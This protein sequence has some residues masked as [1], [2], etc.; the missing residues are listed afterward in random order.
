[1]GILHNE[2]HRRAFVASFSRDKRKPRKPVAGAPGMCHTKSDRRPP[3]ASKP[4]I[5]YRTYV[6]SFLLDCFD[7]CVSYSLSPLRFWCPSWLLPL[8]GSSISSPKF[9]RSCMA[10]TVLPSSKRPWIFSPSALVFY[11]APSLAWTTAHFSRNAERWD[12]SQ[13]EK[14]NSLD[15]PSQLQLW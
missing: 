3:S 1:M 15:L 13:L 12:K 6:P 8:S 7:L 5:T 11:A 9:C 10:P 2:G 4:W 14:T